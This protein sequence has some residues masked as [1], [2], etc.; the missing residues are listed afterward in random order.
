MGSRIPC[1][2]GC[3]LQVTY[4]T[5]KNHLNSRGKSSLRGRVLGTK[6]FGRQQQ[7]SIAHQN[8]LRGSKKRA[9]SNHDQDGSHKWHKTAEP[10]ENQWDETAATFQIDTDSIDPLPAEVAGTSQLTEVLERTRHA[11][12]W[13]WG[14]SRQ[15][16]HFNGSAKDDND[17]KDRNETGSEDEDED[18][19]GED[20]EDGQGE[21]GDE[22]E[23]ED[24][25]GRGEDEE[26]GRGEDGDEYEGKDKDKDEDSVEDEGGSERLGLSAWD[27]LGEDFE[28]EAAF[29][30]GLSSSSEPPLPS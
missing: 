18:G 3:G 6:S 7:E 2:C 5:K 8:Q 24:G 17:D 20:E 10:E 9:S 21:D 22:D 13:W 4:S 14:T 19:Q 12:D 27:Q 23:G 28:R 1:T 16:N 30:M 29:V 25:D 26:D 11:M 15:E